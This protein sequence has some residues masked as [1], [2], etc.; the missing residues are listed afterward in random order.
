MEPQQ[1]LSESLRRRCNMPR[2][3]QQLSQNHS[4]SLAM[5]KMSQELLL[6]RA[7]LNPGM[8]RPKA[9]AHLC[10]TPCS[11]VKAPYFTPSRM[12]TITDKQQQQKMSY[13]DVENW[14]LCALS[15][16]M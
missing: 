3:F 9:P 7:S 4:A 15:V 12:T 8:G 11:E 5:G 16:G 14:S 13:V 10:K 6:T 1:F 2:D